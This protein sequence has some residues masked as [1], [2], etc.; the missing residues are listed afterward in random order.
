MNNE[1]IEGYK[2][3]M[4]LPDRSSVNRCKA[5]ISAAL[6]VVKVEKPTQTEAV[7]ETATEAVTTINTITDTERE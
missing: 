1:V 6:K 2:L 4:V 5:N 7:I 3:S